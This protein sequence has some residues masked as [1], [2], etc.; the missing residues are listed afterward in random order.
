MNI[1]E[2]E[3]YLV[4]HG[5]VLSRYQ[6]KEVLPGIIQIAIEN[7]LA[8]MKTDIETPGFYYNNETKSLTIV[9]FELNDTDIN[10]MN[11]ALDLIEEDLPKNRWDYH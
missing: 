5:Y 8:I 9:E 2:M 11:M 6:L 1:V 10:K 3:Q 7:D 4:E